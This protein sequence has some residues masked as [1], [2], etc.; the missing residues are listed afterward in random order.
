MFNNVKP[1]FRTFIQG[2]YLAKMQPTNEAILQFIWKNRLF[3]AQNLFTTDGKPIEILHP[4]YY[5]TDSGPDFQNARIRIDQQLWAGNVE[6]HIRT[7]DWYRHGHHTDKAYQNVV[8]HVVAVHD[9]KDCPAGLPVLELK[10][11]IDQE[12]I[13][14]AEHLLHSADDIP[15]H[16]HIS[17]VPPNLLQA[18][19]HRTAVERMESKYRE[20]LSTLQELDFDFH[21]WFQIELFTAFGLKANA[22]PMRSLA[23][24]IPLQYLLKSSDQRVSLEALLY[25]VASLLPAEPTDP[26][27]QELLL[28]FDFLKHKY[29]ITDVLPAHVWKFHRLQPVSFPTLRLS[30]L[31]AVFSRWEALISAVFKLPDLLAVQ[32]LLTTTASPY[33]S[34]HYRFGVKSS[35]PHSRSVGRDLVGRIIINAVLPV[36]TGF[37]KYSG[38]HELQE[39]AIE[40]LETLPPE[41][42]RVTRL[43][44]TYGFTNQSALESQGLL[45]LKNNYCLRKK[46]LHCSIGYKIIKSQ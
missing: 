35:S 11:L 10:D 42:N 16:A 4:G 33:W 2:I 7:S 13:S 29:Q 22:E 6:V 8:L 15:C 19:V 30:Q 23:R 3:P 38:R 28:E 45:E 18:M 20:K 41:S 21:R 27:T 37:S 1:P 34:E 5:N 43:M 26:Y 39:A 9:K 25:G 17:S 44:S 36:M 24:K 31:A 32:H 40:W 14:R 12:L 46:C